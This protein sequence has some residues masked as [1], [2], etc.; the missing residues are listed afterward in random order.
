MSTLTDLFSSNK[1]TSLRMGFATIAVS[2]LT[3]CSTTG[4]YTPIGSPIEKQSR[5]N[6]TTCGIKTDISQKVL[7]ADNVEKTVPL[8]TK[9]HMDKDCTDFEIL[10]MIAK[11]EQNTEKD[12]L[13]SAGVLLGIT[14]KNEKIRKVLIEAM[15]RN[16]LTKEGLQRQT[17][18]TFIKATV[19][20][21][22]R[23]DKSLKSS[24]FT[25]LNSIYHE[26]KLPK[27]QRRFPDI[28]TKLLRE[29]INDA[30]DQAGED[31]DDL[32]REYRQGLKH[33]SKCATTTS[34]N[35]F[36]HTRCTGE[37]MLQNYTPAADL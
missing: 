17:A 30:L 4:P 12:A 1:K 8:G 35:G 33:G 13:A 36:T 29:T 32:N 20:N 6:Q 28:K 23:H 24:E 11:G 21:L 22:R 31:L 10:T 9:L 16:D 15:K 18:L 14:S 7:T 2:L 19:D 5:D 37:E 3:A 34:K 26:N 25:K 27:E